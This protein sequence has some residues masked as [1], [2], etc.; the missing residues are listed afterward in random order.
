[1]R[2][3]SFEVE[4]LFGI[5][6][7]TVKLNQE[8]R[9]TI[10]YGPNGFGK[11]T[12]LRLIRAFFSADFEIFGS[13][14]FKRFS[15]RLD[16]G[17]EIRIEKASPPGDSPDV[18]RCLISEL[19]GEQ[20]SRSHLAPTLGLQAS[21][22]RQLEEVAPFMRPLRDD[23]WE[24][25]R[26][27]EVLSLDELRSRF[28]VRVE[29]TNLPD[30][31]EAATSAID[32][33]LIATQR[34]SESSAPASKPERPRIGRRIRR[35][36][37]AAIVNYAGQLSDTM[38]DAFLEYGR[39]SQQLDRTFVVRLLTKDFSRKNEPL[40]DKSLKSRID[41]LNEKRRRLREAGLLTRDDQELPQPQYQYPYIEEILS[42]YLQDV[43]DKLNIF[44]KL[45][46]KIELLATMTK[47]RLKF[48]VMVFSQNEGFTFRTASG[49]LLSPEGLSSG[50]QHIL[51]QIYD[52][53][54]SDKPDSLILIDEP[55]ISLH[56][57]WQLSF[58]EGLHQ[59]TS[60]VPHD[61][62]LATHSPQ[63]IGERWDLTV[64]LQEPPKAGDSEGLAQ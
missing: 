43:E 31:L 62:V 34:L 1:M 12:L 47:D 59:I 13:T 58:L 55:E 30:W 19:I 46:A 41:N 16:D 8:E 48:K 28:G 40:P 51:I 4:K 18:S 54:F 29:K 24:D 10:V 35:T 32:V 27:G 63:I 33:R 11:T 26:D 61:I 22:A 25:I 49:E 50:E 5:F 57:A 21:V 9:V 20:V 15:M 44:D 36:S 45:L 52:L 56:V 60:L 7:H 17:R 2:I 3:T 42:A 39:R 53:L 14:P 6:D 37:S 38:R 64:E 23:R